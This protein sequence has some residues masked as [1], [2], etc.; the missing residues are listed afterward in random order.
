[1]LQIIHLIRLFLDIQNQF[2]FA[3]SMPEKMLSS[4]K[5]ASVDR[6]DHISEDYKFVASVDIFSLNFYQG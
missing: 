2:Y 4:T 5:I 3:E 1:M 6:R